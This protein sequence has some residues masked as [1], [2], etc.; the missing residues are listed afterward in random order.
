MPRTL[1]R[2]LREAEKLEPQVWYICSDV[3]LM[4][5]DIDSFLALQR[6]GRSLEIPDVI[7][8]WKSAPYLLNFMDEYDLKRGFVG[9]VEG[10]RTR[11]EV[12]QAL[13]G[14]TGALLSR[15]TVSAYGQLDP[16]NARLRTL[17]TKCWTWKRG[18]FCGCH[19]PG[20]TTS[21]KA[22]SLSLG[23]RILP[24]DLFSLRGRS[25][26]KSWRQS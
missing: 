1:D 9:A 13:S 19:P 3:R 21:P 8:Y 10:S 22:N 20:I 23:L 11:P 12:F 14:D 18:D 2:S 26:R 5:R 24:N 6:L 7:E 15:E 16:G 25:Y 17:S 4:E